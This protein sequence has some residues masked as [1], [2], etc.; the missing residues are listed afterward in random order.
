[1]DADWSVELGA[2]DAALEFPWFSPDGSQRYVD[3]QRHKEL[4]AE[5][6]E[7]GQFP[8]LGEFLHAIN[9]ART[10]WRTA[11]C[12]VWFN[13]ELG[14]AEAIYDARL[15]LCSYVDLILREDAA[16]LSFERHEQWVKSAA[17]ALASDDESPVACEFIV[18]RCWYHAD[19]NHRRSN[20][21]EAT[22]GDK[23]PVPGFYVSFYLFG[24][25]DVEDEAR[26]RWA[27][28]LLQAAAMLTALAA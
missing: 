6:P 10:P 13:D 11:K 5:I 3:L 15:K 14:E 4:L 28:G 22:Q 2:D 12:D 17:G 23:S 27:A 18:R 1:M 24:Y 19:A 20:D 25:G 21:D 16:R 9:R 26:T 8:E 7:A